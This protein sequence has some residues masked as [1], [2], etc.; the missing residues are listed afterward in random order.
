MHDGADGVRRSALLEILYATGLRVSEL[1][2]LPLSAVSRDGRILIVRG[3]GGKER[4]VPLSDPAMEAVRSLSRGARFGSFP[5]GKAA[6]ASR[7]LFP[8]RAQGRPDS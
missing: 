7:W 3:K 2:G 8:S 1:V 6:R 5:R 4:M